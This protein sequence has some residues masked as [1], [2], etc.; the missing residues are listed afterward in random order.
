MIEIYI[1]TSDLTDGS[2]VYDL[3]IEQCEN[4]IV[5]YCNDKRQAELL[6]SNLRLTLSNFGFLGE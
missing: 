3:V 6:E 2:E 5:L 1:R 4:Q